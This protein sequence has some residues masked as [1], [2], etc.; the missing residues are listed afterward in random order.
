M[1]QPRSLDGQLIGRVSWKGFV[2][3]VL[4]LS[5]SFELSNILRDLVLTSKRTSLVVIKVRVSID[6]DGGILSTQCT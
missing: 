4:P 1:C 2:K 6:F 3:T 5:Q